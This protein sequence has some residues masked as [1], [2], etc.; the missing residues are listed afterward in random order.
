MKQIESHY[1]WNCAW[2]FRRKLFSHSLKREWKLWFIWRYHPYSALLIFS[3]WFNDSWKRHQIRKLFFALIYT[4]HCGV[5]ESILIVVLGGWKNISTSLNCWIK[6]NT[7]TRKIRENFYVI[8]FSRYCDGVE[9]EDRLCVWQFMLI[10]ILFFDYTCRSDRGR[11]T[12]KK[13]LLFCNFHI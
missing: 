13:I 1:E 5:Y 10:K 9:V 12:C 7:I 2:N 3:L 11:F 4:A 8:Y 6:I